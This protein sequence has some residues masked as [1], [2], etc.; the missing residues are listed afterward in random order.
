MSIFREPGPQG[1]LS[2]GATRPRGDLRY[3]VAAPQ[4][5][6]Q[7]PHAW[8]MEAD[9]DPAPE[10]PDAE[11]YRTVGYVPPMRWRPLVHGAG[12]VASLGLVAG[13]V[14]WG[15]GEMRRDLSRVPVIAASDAPMRVAPEVP[16]GQVSD[17]AGFAVN[18]VKAGETSE[19]RADGIRRAPPDVALAE[20][21]RPM[22]G[23]AGNEQ[24]REQAQGQAQGQAGHAAA[25][26][27]VIA[28]A[29]ESGGPAP[30][31]RLAAPE[32]P[33]V[34]AA[35]PALGVPEGVAP[36]IATA[37]E[38]AAAHAVAASLTATLSAAPASAPAP[39]DAE[40]GAAEAP[41]PA[42]APPPAALR[43]QPRPDAT[44]ARL[45][46]SDDAGVQVASLAPIGLPE[47][48]DD[49]ATVAPG[50]RLVQLGAFDS[51]ETARAEWQRLADRFA[52][53]ME[54]KARL[55]Q[56]GGSDPQARWRL[57]AEGFD[58][59]AQARRFCT[60]LIAEGAD[61]I[62]VVAR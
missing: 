34:L 57:R 12:A 40:A 33:G 23:L 44:E 47:P 45:S 30:A 24:A 7:A 1:P 38:I 61:C 18:R 10:T 42:A 3:S 8:A 53:L 51:A 55:V 35:A 60:A 28:P 32:T 6:R 62:P 21:D 9:A 20:E 43:P 11:P 39:E 14:V 41:T 49:G 29:P 50:T 4:A 26:A 25:D 59:L 31:P 54:G 19:P 13:L 48:R 27:P 2:H 46:S 56:E 37:E 17:Q 58:D 5:P 52:P 36:A 22:P 15:A 16:G